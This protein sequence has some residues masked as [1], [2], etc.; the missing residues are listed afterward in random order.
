MSPDEAWTEAANNESPPPH[1]SVGSN[2]AL[3]FSKFPDDRMVFGPVWW[4]RLS[5]AI[6]AAL[7]ASPGVDVRP[8]EWVLNEPGFTGQSAETPVGRYNTWRLPDKGSWAVRSESMPLRIEPNESAA[9]LAADQ[10]YRA[11]IGT[12]LRTAGGGG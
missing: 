7:S 8:L 6:N 5:N 12:A 4:A 1:G 11:R 9:K 10:H 2:I 3:H